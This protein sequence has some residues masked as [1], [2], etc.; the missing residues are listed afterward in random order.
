[1]H[2]FHVTSAFP[3]AYLIQLAGRQ[4]PREFSISSY[5]DKHPTE[6]HLTMAVT[7]YTTTFKRHK[8]GVCSYWLATQVPETSDVIPLWLEKG[9]MKLPVIKDGETKTHPVIMVGPGTGVAAFRS[10]IQYLS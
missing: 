10:F 7:D 1:M 6:I 3:L 8:V 2:D 9:T 4:K 5:H